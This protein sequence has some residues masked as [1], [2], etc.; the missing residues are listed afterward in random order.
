M[1]PQYQLRGSLVSPRSVKEI[2]HIAMRVRGILELP[3]L[4]NNM[5]H[6][7]EKLFIFGIT[8]D[9]VDNE[10]MG[11]GGWQH[12]E[13]CCNPETAVIWLP[14]NTYCDACNNEPRAKFT[15]FHELGH[16]LLAHR[17]ILHRNTTNNNINYKP[18]EDSE[19]QADQF[20]AEILMPLEEIRLF[21]LSTTE[22]I[23][24]LFGV[25]FQAADNRIR[26]LTRAK[27][28]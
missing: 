2:R 21:G 11:L 13:A 14:N 20:A 27:E 15:I 22:Q 9:V 24:N 28:I 4:I 1:M 25:S 7:L 18:Y 16:I 26:K 3:R 17:R 8:I 12:S 19:W 10:S 23:Q 6:F 5:E